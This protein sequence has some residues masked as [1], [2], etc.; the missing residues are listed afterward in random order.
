MKVGQRVGG[1]ASGA[2]CLLIGIWYLSEAL[3]NLK[4]WTPGNQ[5]GGGFFP[6]LLGSALILLS[7]FLLYK[8]FQIPQEP[9]EDRIVIEREEVIKPL[10]VLVSLALWVYLFPILGYVLSTWLLTGGLMW[11]FGTASSPRKRA[12]AAI[13]ISVLGVI[14]F[15]GIFGVIFALELPAWPSFG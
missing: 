1:L 9:G 3:R 5:P 13:V 4:F 8:S 12:L 10:S 7:C 6:T 2:I 11:F 15:Y 14:G